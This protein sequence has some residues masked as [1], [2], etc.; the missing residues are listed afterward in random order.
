MIHYNVEFSPGAHLAARAS[1]LLL[2]VAGR[3]KRSA[4]FCSFCDGHKYKLKIHTSTP[5][6]C[7]ANRAGT[8]SSCQGFQYRVWITRADE[9]NMVGNNDFKSIDT[10]VILCIML[11]HT[12]SAAAG[13]VIF[14]TFFSASLKQDKMWSWINIP[15]ENF[16]NLACPLL[17]KI[18]HCTS[19]EII[20][21][22]HLVH[23]V[24]Q[25]KLIMTDIQ[26]LKK[27]DA[28]I[29]LYLNMLKNC[30]ICHENHDNND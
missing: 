21:Q 28:N 10:P 11:L 9:N 22:R 8:Q 18:I 24:W 27:E 14:T 26:K 1:F 17:V 4:L 19:S 20:P 3:L 13:A 23:T 6:Q 12:S 7:S 25:H 15:V 2:A 5:H 16:I 30:W 29:K